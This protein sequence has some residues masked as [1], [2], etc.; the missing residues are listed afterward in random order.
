MELVEGDCDSSACPRNVQLDIGST[1]LEWLQQ[2]A[3]VSFSQLIEHLYFFLKK[4]NLGNSV[5]DLRVNAQGV[6]G[7]SAAREYIVH[8]S[9]CTSVS[10]HVCTSLTR[11]LVYLKMICFSLIIR[12]EMMKWCFFR[13]FRKSKALSKTQTVFSFSPLFA[14]WTTKT[15]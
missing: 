10:M 11:V 4:K 3:M 5:K 13:K 12:V 15:S 6:P 7:E 1:S 8:L 14:S 2:K 9:A